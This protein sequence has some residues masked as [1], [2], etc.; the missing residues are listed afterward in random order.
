MIEMMKHD[1]IHLFGKS[2]PVER[3][4]NL[5]AV[6]SFTGTFILPWLGSITVIIN[7]VVLVL[8]GVI[9]SKTKKINHKP[10]FLFI[11]MLSLFDMLVGG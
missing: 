3:L 11:G 4:L 5:R 9:Y 6:Q 10:A 2:D 1:F 7:L 8:S